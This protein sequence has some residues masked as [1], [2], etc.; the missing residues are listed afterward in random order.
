VV[1]LAVAALGLPF[2]PAS[3]VE[4]LLTLR[5]IEADPTGSAQARW[6]GTVAA[7]EHVG[8][9]PIL[10][11]GLGMN[12]LVLN[13]SVG[14]TWRVVHNTYL[15]YAVDLGVPGLVL[16]GL[17]L[18]RSWQ[19]ARLARALGSTETA[20]LAEGVEISLVGFAVAAVF[21]P[22]AYQFYFF[23]IAGLAV[24]ARI[25]A[26]GEAAGRREQATA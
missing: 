23:Y 22:V 1:A 14:A 4:R 26:A 18:I 6:T 21:Q 11:A 17:L 2:V 13:E 12:I 16:F 19:S 15:E 3:Y 7:L 20:Q 25:V 9:N 24:A 5:S 10:G 8:A